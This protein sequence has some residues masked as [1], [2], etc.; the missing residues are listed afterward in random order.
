M[1]VSRIRLGLSLKEPPHA[2]NGGP[3]R[4]L[5]LD[6]NFLPVILGTRPRRI[7]PALIKSFRNFENPKYEKVC[8]PKWPCAASF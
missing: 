2:Q 4:R 8:A 3:R 1:P 7:L 6:E 5:S